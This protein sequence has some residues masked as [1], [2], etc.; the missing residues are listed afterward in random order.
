MIAHE[1]I[2]QQQLRHL[3]RKSIITMAGNVRLKIY[4]KL[5]CRSGKRMTRGNRVFFTSEEDAMKNHFRPCGHC[6][7]VEY[8]IRKNGPL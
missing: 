7:N 4:G 6:M 1:E 2:P 8:K 5:N 3:I